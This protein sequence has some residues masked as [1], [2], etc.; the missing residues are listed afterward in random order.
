M[1]KE[2]NL[3]LQGEG[4]LAE[5]W[6]LEIAQGEEEEPNPVRLLREVPE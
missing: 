1:Q 2:R 5:P 6:G 4:I 3:L